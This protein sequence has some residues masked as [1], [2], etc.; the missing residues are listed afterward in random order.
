M[1]LAITAEQ[2]QLRATVRRFLAEEAPLTRVREAAAEPDSWDC[3]LWRRM[4][5]DIGV[6]GLAV[7]PEYGGA[8][9]GFQELSYVFE[10][11]G[12]ALLTGPYYATFGLVLPALLACRDADV[13]MRY[14]PG[15]AD[16]TTTA[17]LAGLA[18]GVGWDSWGQDITA[19][20]TPKGWRVTGAASA[21]LDATTAT[22]LLVVARTGPNLHIFAAD[23]ND[24]SVRRSPQPTL[25]QTRPVGAVEFHDTPATPITD[26]GTRVLS[27]ALDHANLLL[28]AD[29]IGGA[30]ACLDMSV[31]YAKSREQFGRPIG[32]FQ[33]IKHTCAE[34][35]VELEGA[36][37]ATYYAAWAA[38]DNPSELP[39]VATLAK[40]TAGETYFRAAADNVQIHG[41]IGF[42]WEHD[43]H[44]YFKR[45]KASQ[46]LF[47]DTGTFRRR[48]ADRIGL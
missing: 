8:G 48:L 27:D 22:L 13:R 10:E 29:M 5:E 34:N 30:Q 38:D 42:T 15:I 26:D 11:G 35:L 1:S 7:P 37:S 41:G 25:D 23:P 19:R 6:H 45:A 39:I 3:E 17:T 43:A 18:P 32:S 16:G 40:A 21:V 2:D 9:A 14:L 46:L 33:A 4:A 28:A 36:R 31:A 20:S 44:L 24:Q 12:R 47:G